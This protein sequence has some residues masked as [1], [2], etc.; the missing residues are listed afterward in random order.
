MSEYCRYS[1]SSTACVNADIGDGTADAPVTATQTKGYWIIKDSQNTL[2]RLGYTTDSEQEFVN[3]ISNGGQMGPW[4][5]GPGPGLD[6]PG[7]ASGAGA[8]IRSKTVSVTPPIPPLTRPTLTT[9]FCSIKSIPPGQ[10]DRFMPCLG[11]S[12]ASRMVT[13]RSCRLLR[14][15]RSKAAFL[16][17][18]SSYPD[19]VSGKHTYNSN[20]NQSP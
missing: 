2:Y 15:G 19:A 3:G 10:T 5:D 12:S 16:M 14:T 1:T 13:T 17:T 6:A 18:G 20:P 7:F 11:I 9:N 4:Q 8:S